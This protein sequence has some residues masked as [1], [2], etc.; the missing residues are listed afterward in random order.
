MDIDNVLH[1]GHDAGISAF[2]YDSGTGQFTDTSFFLAV[3]GVRSLGLSAAQ[4][5]PVELSRFEIE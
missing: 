3:A 4:Q 1:V 2:T 5:V